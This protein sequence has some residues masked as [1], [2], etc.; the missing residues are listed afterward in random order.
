MSL[1]FPSS[2]RVL[3]ASGR[4]LSLVGL[5]LALL[6]VIAWIG[7]L[8]QGTITLYETS[9]PLR[10][11]RDALLDTP[12]V[13]ATF[14]DSAFAFIQQGQE[15]YLWLESDSADSAIPLRVQIYDIQE[16]GEHQ[17]LQT[18]VWVQSPEAIAALPAGTLAGRVRIV[19]G[20]VRPITLFL[21]ETGWLAASSIRGDTVARSG[22]T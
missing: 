13:A 2:T 11:N 10:V 9:F 1:S 16:N 7:W 21:R 18:T 6:L 12:V 15:A 20:Q 8:F 14:P 17:P 4:R 5:T 3:N 19:A 22:G